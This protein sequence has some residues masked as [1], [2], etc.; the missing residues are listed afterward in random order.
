LHTAI[1]YRSIRFVQSAVESRPP[2]KREDRLSK[3]GR[4]RSFPRVPCLLQFVN[5]GSYFARTKIKGK[6]I[7][8]SLGTTVWST[9][10]LRLV[11]FLKEK[12]EET[13]TSSPAPRFTEALEAYL[14][15]LDQNTR[16]KPQSKQYRR[17]CVRRIELSWPALWERRI[18][19]ISAPECRDWAAQLVRQ[20]ACHYYNNTIGTL[21]QI[22]DCGIQE[23]VARGGPKLDNPARELSLTRIRQKQLELPETDQFRALVANVRKNSGGWGHKAADLIEFLAYSGLRI[24][25]EAVW[26]NWEDIDWQRRE[27]IV[28]GDP[29]TGT[30]NSESRRV[31][32][33][34]DM[35][36]LLERMGQGRPRSGRILEATRCN[37]S[38]ARACR[39][40]GLKRNTHHDL[41]HL[42]A[43]RCIESGVDV[44]T[45]AR[46][47]GHKDGGAL[48]M[49]TYGHLRNEHSQ[50]MAQRVRF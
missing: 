42:F 9:A 1:V 29:D 18:D 50:A 40:L 30:K 36:S 33:I 47:L 25:S 13:S 49:R 20:I 37:E 22:L 6:L 38:L 44:P 39:E 35:A 46:W 41:R 11:D 17:W 43:T 12:R 28:R 45:V 26:V 5:S 10:R 23:S 16:I 2:G 31:P 21:R 19:E 48:A 8:Q 27:I 4:W 14:R 34:P 24:G 7:R 32:L 15:K 3:D